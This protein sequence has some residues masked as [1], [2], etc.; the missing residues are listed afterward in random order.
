MEDKLHYNYI[1]QDILFGNLLQVSYIR[2]K[3]LKK[4]MNVAHL[5]K[6]NLLILYA[7]QSLKDLFEEYLLAGGIKRGWTTFNGK[8]SNKEN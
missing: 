4:W 2:E 3:Y 5:Q 6:Y 8:G 1:C 7:F